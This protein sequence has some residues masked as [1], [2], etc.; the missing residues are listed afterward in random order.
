[1]ITDDIPAGTDKCSHLSGHMGGV[2]HRNAQ[3]PVDISK[4]NGHQ[5]VNGQGIEDALR[6]DSDTEVLFD[7]EQD[8]V[9]LVHNGFAAQGKQGRANQSL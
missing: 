8:A 6:Q 1:M 2:F 5:P 4:G 9:I 7:H 3:C